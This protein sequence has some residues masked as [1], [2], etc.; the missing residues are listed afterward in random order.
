[1]WNSCAKLKR[2]EEAL[3]YRGLD[4]KNLDVNELASVLRKRG[5][6]D[7]KQNDI[8]CSLLNIL[9]PPS[10][11]MTHC[12]NYG[13]QSSFCNCSD[14]KIPGR[15]SIYLAYKKRIKEKGI[16]AANELIELIEDHFGEGSIKLIN[17][18][19]HAYK[20]FSGLFDIDEKFTLTKKWS[21]NTRKYAWEEIVRRVKD[22]IGQ[23]IYKKG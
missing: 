22:A 21:D 9:E 10:C 20:F 23:K 2:F 16:K 1:M 13:G 12:V 18:D 15:C 17:I 7:N 5:I 6:T 11:D 8:I 4:A 3:T 14:S 19:D